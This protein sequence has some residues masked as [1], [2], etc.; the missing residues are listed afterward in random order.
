M[1]SSTYIRSVCC[2]VLCNFLAVC[3]HARWSKTRQC[4]GYTEIQCK[5]EFGIRVLGH[6]LSNRSHDA[7]CDAQVFP[8][9]TVRIQSGPNPVRLGLPPHRDALSRPSFFF[10]SPTV[11][12]AAV[13]VPQGVCLRGLCGEVVWP[14]GG[15]NATRTLCLCSLMTVA[16]S[17][18]CLF[19]GV[20]GFWN[21][22]LVFS[23][24]YSF[25]CLMQA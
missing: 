23:E 21:S 17:F 22:V 14:Q 20:L 19:A 10:R 25:T 24:V 5:F 2:G 7:T 12:F 18:T 15:S 8:R 6:P 3:S 4:A 11:C 1:V 13:V 16:S 9:R